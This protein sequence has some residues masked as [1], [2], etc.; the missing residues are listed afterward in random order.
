MPTFENGLASFEIPFTAANQQ[1]G[2]NV[3]F[4][5]AKDGS[6]RELVVVMR[7]VSGFNPDPTT[8]GGM[9]LYGF[10]N[11]WSASLGNW[12]N[13]VGNDAV[14]YVLDLDADDDDFDPTNMNAVGFSFQTG[15]ATAE[16]STALFEVDCMGFRDKD[17]DMD[18]S[19]GPDES[20]DEP[21]AGV[22][23]GG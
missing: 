16:S 21:D 10:S 4:N 2:W 14:E 8:P 6:G 11:S 19:M 17:G 9:Q 23:A 18:A 20:G 1:Y 22:D 3:E 15:G 13:I 5:R 7:L 12:T